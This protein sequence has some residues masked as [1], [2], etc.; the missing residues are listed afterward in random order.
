MATKRR[1]LFL[2][3]TLVCFF[4]LIAIFVVDG[5]MGIYDTTYIT[6]GER[7]QKIEADTW[8]KSDSF[9]S[10]GVN[11][12]E[13]AF[14]RYEVANR[15]F[16]S[17]SADIEV[18]VWRMQEKVL[19]V[20]SQ[21]ITVDSFGRGQLEWVID[22]TELLPESTSPEQS[23]EFTV[24]IKRGEMERRI[25]IYINPVYPAKLVPPTPR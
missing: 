5:Y 18:S 21:P 10:A 19:D 24:I 13:K 15:Q 7:E 25:I 20:V 14:F 3:L 22:T 4:G 12:G 9:W 8:L 17:Y 1:N 11:W 2:Y 23:Y 6:A 16:S